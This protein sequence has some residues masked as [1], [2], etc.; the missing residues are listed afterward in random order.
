MFI[1]LILAG[2]VA[3]AFGLLMCWGGSMSDASDEGYQRRGLA[4]IAVG[5]VAVV[6]GI[7]GLV[8]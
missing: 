7:V 1:A 8:L 5:A 3:A 6:G 4:V 2:I